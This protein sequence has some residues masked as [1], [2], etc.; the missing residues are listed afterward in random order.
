VG[1]GVLGLLYSSVALLLGLS[2]LRDKTASLVAISAGSMVICLGLT[3]L[4]LPAL[5]V[6]RNQDTTDV[7]DVIS[8]PE[9][10]ITIVERDFELTIGRRRS[11]AMVLNS[12]YTMGGSLSRPDERR[13]AILPLMMHKHPSQVAC[14]GLATGITAGATLDIPGVE[15]V[16]AIELSHQV[17]KGAE[18]YFRAHNNDFFSSRRVAVVVEDARTYIATCDNKFDVVI[19]DLFRP[20]ATGEGRLFAVEHF[21]SVKRALRSGGLFCQWLPCYQLNAEEF[22]VILASFLEV[23]DEADIWRANLKSQFTAIG[24]CGYR[25]GEPDFPGLSQRCK[26]LRE[27]GKVL[28]PPSRH[29]E[30]IAMHYIGRLTRNDAKTQQLNTLDNLWVE[31][32]AGRRHSTTDPGKSSLTNAQWM[33]FETELFK[34]VSGQRTA[35]G[36]LQK[37]GDVGRKIVNWYFAASKRDSNERQLLMEAQGSLPQSVQDDADA[38]WSY[39]PAY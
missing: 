32:H 35:A 30:S 1:F 19:G 5:P 20:Y 28:D 17:A 31:L 9:G 38:D 25:S 37:W 24:L 7:L 3:G 21:Q 18:R 14:L 10:V 4:W 29:P 34:R 27:S 33:R 39:W 16:T 26:Q 15:H 8:G 13:Q 6:A 2:L 36:E 12:Q 11:R 23:F 22:E